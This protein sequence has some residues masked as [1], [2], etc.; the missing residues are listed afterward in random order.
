MP[1]TTNVVNYN[2]SHNEVYSIQHYVIKF[3]QCLAAGRWFSPDTPVSSTN[4]NNRHANT[5]MVNITWALLQTTWGKDEPF[6]NHMAFNMNEYLYDYHTLV[7]RE[8][9]HKLETICFTCKCTIYIGF[10]SGF[11]KFHGGRRGRDHMV[12]GLT[13]T[14]VI[15]ARHHWRCKL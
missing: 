14:C 6:I 1:V 12:V 11:L 7:E 8:Y 9:I 10:R 3:C 13:T 2:P 15:N 5:N 4:K